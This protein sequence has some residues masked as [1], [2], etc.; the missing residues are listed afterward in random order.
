[1]MRLAALI[2]LALPLAAQGPDLAS[3]RE[4]WDRL[5]PEERGLLEQRFEEFRALDG[6]AQRALEERAARIEEVEEELL[7]SVPDELE[8]RMA[9]LDP[10]RR[11][12]LWREHLEDEMRRRGRRHRD[13]LPPELE[14]Q[15]EAAPPHMRPLLMDR[16]HHDRRERACGPGLERLG[17]KLGK[18]DEEIEAL[19]A[20][21][22]EERRDAMLAWK[23]EKILLSVEREGLPPGVDPA[24][25]EAWKTLPL[26]DFFEAWRDAD[27][28]SD[29]RGPFRDAGPAEGRAP[30]PG[31][32]SDGPGG[33][34]AFGG[35]REGGRGPFG[36]SGR[37]GGRSPE[38]H[39]LFHRV[40]K[41]AHPTLEERLEFAGLSRAE[42]DERIGERVR[43]RTLPEL[44]SSG[45]V[46]AEDLADLEARVGSDYVDALH[47]LIH[48]GRTRMRPG[49][50][51][52]GFG[53][54][55]RGE[56]GPRGFRGS[57]WDKRED[58][59]GSERGS[60]RGSDAEGDG[61]G[62]RPDRAPRK[63]GGRR[64][65]RF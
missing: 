24:E 19:R 62:P 17:R 58:K 30:D 56:R 18:G 48:P 36:P 54:R 22:G 31:R 63:P 29:V 27:P 40:G 13:E 42:R 35:P 37:R 65:D 7:E 49:D 44:R 25:F 33:P 52:P 43:A 16:Y 5:S 9:D 21:S 60:E 12:D 39:E 55:E 10:H 51:S 34:G 45:L 28:R 53:P 3:S 14:A 8:R 41:L 4:R 64:F 11:D 61:D 38:T 15:L 2:L 23:R 59:R 20:L 26:G 57:R 46:D 47:A 50:G 1:M 32:G 6:A